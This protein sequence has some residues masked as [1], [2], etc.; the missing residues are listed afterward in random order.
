MRF[1]DFSIDAQR[2]KKRNEILKCG[3]RDSGTDKALKRRMHCD[4]RDA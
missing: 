2:Q 4:V 3:A 1:F